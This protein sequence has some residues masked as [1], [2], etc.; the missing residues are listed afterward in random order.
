MNLIDSGSSVEDCDD[1]PVSGT[2]A[3]LILINYNDVQKIY[4]SDIGVITAVEMKAGKV[5]YEFTGFRSDVKKSDEVVRRE[6]SNRRFKHIVS[7]VVYETSQLQKNNLKGLARGRFIGVVE[8]NGK[9]DNSIE[10]LGKDV[11]LELL[12]GMIRD[13]HENGGFFIL[14]LSTPDNGVEFERRLPQTLG[15]DYET[16]LEIIEDILTLG[17]GI[18]DETFD[19]TFE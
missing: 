19:E 16:G 12:G 18:F 5:G 6:Q 11:G 14:N 3:R 1:L 7:F 15:I 17:E 13:A 4:Y 10:L 2:R 9:D 8:N